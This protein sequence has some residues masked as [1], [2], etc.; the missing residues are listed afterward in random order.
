[1]TPSGPPDRTVRAVLFDR[2]GTLV[3]DVPYNGDPALV[4]PVRTAADAL[5]LLR[6]RRIPVAIVTNQSG[7]ARG[8]FTVDDLRR[9]HERVNDLLGPFDCVEWCPHGDDAG[10]ECRKP[11]PGM[12]LRAARSLGVRPDECALIGDTAADMGAAARAGALGVLVPNDA[13]RPEEVE[14]HPVV[15]GT[16]L[17]AV[18]WLLS[19][20]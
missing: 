15:A 8:L 10:C 14:A 5:D 17:A 13:T 11:R 9:V 3:H 6:S 16:V 4:R 7:I 18:S 2:D 12:V 20:P 19:G 1:M